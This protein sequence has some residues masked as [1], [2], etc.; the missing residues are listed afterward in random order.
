[1]AHKAL[2]TGHLGF[3]GKHLT[4]RLTQDGWDVIGIDRKLGADV[5]FADLPSVDRV[6]HLAAQTNAQDKDAIRDAQTNV[7]GALRVFATYGDKCVFASS[8]MVNY[9][10]CPYAISKRAGEDYA[11]YFGCAVVRF[12]NLYGEGGHSVIDKMR[13]GERIMIYGTGEQVRTY[14]PVEDAIDALMNARP[15]QLAILPGDDYTVNQIADMF[16]GKTID[17]M[18]ANELDMMDARQIY[19]GPMWA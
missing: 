5:Q 11:L 16:P 13:D 1:L 17:H 14:A 2:V 3:V 12:C 7:M 6:F 10:R 9:P 8:S 4:K 18:P 19:P 15:G